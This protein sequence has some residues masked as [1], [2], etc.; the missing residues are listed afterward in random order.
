MGKIKIIANYLPQFHVTR[1]NSQWWGEGYT[2]WEAVKKATPVYEGQIQPREPYNNYYYDLSQKESLKWQAELA[3][4]YGIY[5]FGIYHYWFNSDTNILSKPAEI[6]LDNKD[7]DI[8]YLFIW[9]NAT[10]KRTWSNVK[11]Y[12][13]DWVHTNEDSDGTNGVLAELSYGCEV[14][15]KKHF[16]YLLPFFKDDRYIKINNKPVFTFFNQYNDTEKIQAMISYWNKLAIQS[17][18]EGVYVIGRYDGSDKST[19]DYEYTYEPSYSAFLNKTIAEKIKNKFKT[20][21]LKMKGIDYYQYDKVWGSII[22][23]AKKSAGKKIY[24]GGICAYDDTPRRGKNAKII[25]NSTPEKFRKYLKSLT[26]ISLS[27]G[28][29]Y[30][31]LTAWNEWGEGA[32]LEPDVENEFKYLEA[33]RAVVR[34]SE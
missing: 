14:D 13:N 21:I 9:D 34:E 3:S 15:W 18:F 8:N 5:G 26:D 4:E 25:L 27:Q 29:E 28:K 12:A 17:G 19:L 20:K 10:W 22:E 16:D 31:F 7:I 33:V 11:G 1:E 23:F 2:D 6:L 32:Y 30:L 24:Y